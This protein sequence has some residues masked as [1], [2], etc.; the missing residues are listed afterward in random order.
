VAAKLEDYAI[1]GDCETIAMVARDGSIDWLCWPRF[2]SGACFAALLGSRENGRW[3]IGARDPQARISRR[4]RDGTLILETHIETGTGA[5]TVTDLMPLRGE[6]SDVVRI[7]EGRRGTVGMRTELIIRF[8]YGSLIPWVTRFEDGA[9]K[10]VAGPDMVVLRT[11]VELRAEGLTHVAEFE[12]TA[13]QIIPFVL[14]YS[15]SYGP[16][17]RAID[18]LAALDE[19]EAH[20]KAWSSR[21]VCPE[22]WSDAVRGSLITLKALTHRPTGGIVA[23]ATASIPEQLGGTRNWDYRYCWLR[24][25]T[26]TLLALMNAGY[27]EE[28]EA[29]REWLLRAVAGAPAQTQIMYGLTGE[30]RLA[31]W[32]APWLSGYEGSRPVRFGNAA[33]TQFQLDVFGEVFDALYQG[34]CG[35]LKADAAGWMTQR[36]MLEHL[37]AI[38]ND[39]DEGIWEIRGESRHFIYS[40]VMAW[41]AFDRAIRDVERFGM[42]GPVELWRATRRKIHADVCEKGFDAEIGAFVQSYGSKELDASV[43]LIPLVGFL[44]ASDPRVRSTVDQIERRLLVDG[45]VKRYDAS[46]GVDGLGGGEGAFLSCSFWFVDNLVLLGRIAQA[47]ELF[48]RLLSLRNDVGL[49]SE[50]YDTNAKRLVGNFPQALSH[51]ALVNTAHNLSM[52][53]KPCHQ[54]S[55]SQSA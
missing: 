33:C 50:E 29:W 51:I 54:R 8:D 21:C 5:A 27:F 19:A 34:R 9:L 49:L 14:S 6:A 4:Y 55:L 15:P 47:R 11:E 23:A 41:V 1:V 3:L 12:V 25:A 18:P 26:F 42:E 45:F 43:L 44:P 7:V 17:P 31:E 22:E 46:S 35:R 52:A 53:Q 24:D 20:W 13:G 38:W 32:E 48:E 37:G 2:D 30:R 40:K 28:A 36:A 39:P 10:A 16:P